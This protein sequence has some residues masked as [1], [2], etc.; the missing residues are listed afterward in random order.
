[1]KSFWKAVATYA[2][3]IALWAAE[4]PDQVTAIV[5]EAKKVK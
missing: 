5:D 1:M 2:T 4:H 3:K